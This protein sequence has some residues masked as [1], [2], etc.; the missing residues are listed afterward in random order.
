MAALRANTMHTRMPANC[1]Q[2]SGIGESLRALTDQAMAAESN[3]KGSA[4]SVWLKRIISS[5]CRNLSNMSFIV[6]NPDPQYSSAGSTPL[7]RHGSY[8]GAGTS[9]DGPIVTVVFSLNG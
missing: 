8:F 4:N 9:S 5:S 2:N 1:R 6:L 7:C 3:A